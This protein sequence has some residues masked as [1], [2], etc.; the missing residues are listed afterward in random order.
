MERNIIITIIFRILAFPFFFCIF[1]IGA[2]LLIIN[3]TYNFIR[4]GGEASAYNKKVNRVT[5]PEVFL[6]LQ[7]QQNNGKTNN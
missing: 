7:K 3:W 2:V 6:E 1:I 4:Y 5:L